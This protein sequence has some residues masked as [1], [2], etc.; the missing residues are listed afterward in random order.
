VDSATDVLIDSNHLH[1]NGWKSLVENGTG[2]GLDVANSS[3][4]TV[5]D[6]VI[7]DNGNEGFHLSSSSGVLVEDNVFHDNGLEQ[8]YLIHAD[9]NVIRR[10][11]ATGGTQGL[12]MRFSSGNAFSY[13][14]WAGSPLQ[15]LEN[16]NN[17]NTFFYE[18]FEGR[19]AVGDASTGNRFELSSFSNPTGNCLTVASPNVAYVYKGFFGT[20]TWDVVG[21][22]LV[23]LDRSV[24]TLAKV[25]KTVTVRFPGCTADFDLDGSVT[26]ADRLT[27]LAAMGSVIGGAGWEPEADLD[28]D[29]D[30]DAADLAIFDGQLG[31]CAA[32]LVVTLLS[33]PP[34]V[35]V[36]GSAI[37]ITDTVRNQS[38]F[39]AG[40]S[41]I[42]YYLSVDASKNAGDKLLGGRTVPALVPNGESTGT[43][44]VTIPLGTLLGTYFVLACADDTGLVLE[45]GETNNC[46]ASA[47]T[48]QVGRPDLATTEAGSPPLAV[49]LG[50]SF[51]MT[52]TVRN[53][54]IYPAGVSRVQYYLSLDAI[55]SPTD[56][57]LSGSR[58]VVSLAPGGTSSGV[59]TVV[60]PANTPAGTYFVMACADDL[61]QV[62]ES[63]ENNNCRPS[64][65]QVQVGRPDLVSTAVS[66]PPG[67]KVRGTSFSVTDT[68]KNQSEFNAGAF[69]VQYY[70]SLDGVKNVG[71]RLLSGFRT[72][73]GVAAG[74]VSTG[75]M[76]VTIP[77]NTAA[78]SYFLLACADDAVQVI[79]SNETNNCTASTG[80]VTVTIG[81]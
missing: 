44:T 76:L 69:R 38:G 36:P 32:D 55:K 7:T 59:T 31:P 19:V 25:S 48:V 5:R 77:Q 13:N 51:S 15:Y 18:R 33:P 45:S 67:I 20:C 43:A 71:D 49:A 81:P 54:S 30:V 8:L 52:D 2:Y 47:T 60:V 1:D 73:T 28:H 16:D 23:T 80:K 78:A 26:T 41:R 24:N 61:H 6:N 27:I 40:T 10:N 63:D 75:T 3:A 72:L 14:V 9:N 39:A 70:L 65:G 62:L 46:R 66:D 12:E 37:S 79:E 50:G 42:Q 4:V 58:A 68:V 29:G 57:L 11:H 64:A 17:D 34:A 74:A 21:N 22:A 35:A 56:K 53:Q